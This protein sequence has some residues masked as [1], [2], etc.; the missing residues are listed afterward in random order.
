MSRLRRIAL[1]LIKR[2]KITRGKARKGGIKTRRGLAG[3]DNDFPLEVLTGIPADL[4]NGEKQRLRGIP[5]Y[6]TAIVLR[7]ECEIIC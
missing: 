5:K 2:N 1:N 3:W 7:C 4:T 6:S